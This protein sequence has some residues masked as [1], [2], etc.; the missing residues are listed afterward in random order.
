[1]NIPDNTNNIPKKLQEKLE[2][3]PDSP[4]VYLYKNAAGKV[5]YVGKAKILKNRVRSYF[6]KS[7]HLDP[8]TTRLVADIQDLDLITTKNELEALILENSLIKTEKPRY[9]ILLRDDKDWFYLQFTTEED[10]P[11][12]KLIRRPGKKDGLVFGPYIPAYLARKTKSILHKYFGIRTCSRDITGK[13]KRA[14]LQYDMKR[15]CGPCINKDVWPDYQEAA[16]RAKMLLCGK[17][18][19]LLNDL[20]ESMMAAAAKMLYEKAAGFRDAIDVVNRQSEEQR[21]A[22]T[23]FEE[24]DI[25]AYSFKDLKAVMVMFAVRNGI[26]RSKKEFYW[27]EVTS[28]DAENLISTTIQQFYHGV[29]YIPKT[30]L[31]QDNFEDRELLEQWLS[32]TKEQKVEILIPQRGRKKSLLNL[33]V[34]NAQLAWKNRFTVSEKDALLAL[35]EALDLPKLPAHIECFDISHIQGSEQVASMVY[36]NNGKPKKS[37]YRKF[38]IKTVEGSDDFASMNEVVTR[39]Y[40]RLLREN[41]PLPN[42]ILIDGGKGQLSSSIAAL[43]KIGITS[44][45]IA[46]LAKKEE[47]LFTEDQPQGIKLGLA[48]PAVKLVQRI[49]DE[50]HRFAITF[51]RSR[52]AAR[53]LTTSLKKIPGIGDKRAKTLLVK[54]GSLERV[55][56]ASFEDIAKTVGAKSARLIK[57]HFANQQD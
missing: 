30:I 42:L 2:R 18:R 55:K 20:K 33:A 34:E 10:F 13:D 17:T 57:E 53:T 22:S 38:K 48:H 21:I 24:Q 15:C 19:E 39:R 11:R 31:V 52:R 41:K 9:N 16:E 37:E 25:F 12:V 49:R 44:V 3:L 5:I 54:F 50:A 45:P 7:H 8:K 47:I 4:G 29:S 27:N 56:A 6:Q 36:W 23:G 40:S 1:M 35:Q 51:H 26:V 32:D 46:S 28:E 43:E 14:C